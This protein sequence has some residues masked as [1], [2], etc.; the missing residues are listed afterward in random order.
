M[1]DNYRNDV[2]DVTKHAPWT[3]GHVFIKVILPLMALGVALSVIGYG[4][5]WFGEAAQVAREEFGPRAALKKYE[6]FKDS[7]AVLAKKKADIT[8]FDS[9]TQATLDD[10]KEVPRKDWDRTDKETLAQRRIEVAGLKASYN[11]LA[12][13]YNAAMSKFNWGVFEGDPPPGS[14]DLPRDIKPYVTQ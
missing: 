10:L 13:E 9:V 5:G 6:W 14:E 4:L 12:A 11:G 8:V 7:A 3:M 1:S 2:R